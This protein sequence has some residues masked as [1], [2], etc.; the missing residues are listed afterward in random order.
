MID[1]R[2]EY[3]RM[4]EV[5]RT[6]WWYQSLHGRILHH[7]HKH[8]GAPTPDLKIMDAACGTGGL[9]SFL[10]EKGYLNLVGFDYSQHLS[11]IHI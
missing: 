8:F 4:Y 10:R 5:E 6:L 2:A 3:E 11:L 7:I 1:N 9:L